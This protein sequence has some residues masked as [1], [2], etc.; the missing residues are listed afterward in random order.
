MIPIL[1]E[2]TGLPSSS[3]SSP[4]LMVPKGHS[5]LTNLSWSGLCRQHLPVRNYADIG[6][7][8]TTITIYQ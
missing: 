6:E 7:G 3:G 5:L 2:V 1:S 4:R 8:V